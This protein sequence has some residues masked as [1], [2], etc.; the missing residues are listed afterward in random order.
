MQAYFCYNIYYYYYI[1]V[2]VRQKIT[3]R[4]HNTIDGYLVTR[5]LPMEKDTIFY[6]Y[7]T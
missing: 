3:H 5:E 4:I 7:V 1:V 2:S 6:L